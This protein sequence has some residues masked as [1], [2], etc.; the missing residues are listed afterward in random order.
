MSNA[1]R[2]IHV[3]GTV[4]ALVLLAGTASRTQ[5]V[6][7]IPGNAV[8]RTQ[9]AR[10]V[11]VVTSR[12]DVTARKLAEA[13]DAHLN[14]LP[15]HLEVRVGVPAKGAIDQASDAAMILWLGEDGK[16]LFVWCPELED[17]PRPVDV[18]GSP[19][20]SQAWLEA[21]ATAIYSDLLAV[22]PEP[23][24]EA[25]PEE[26][27]PKSSPPEPAASPPPPEARAE[28]SSAEIE[29]P[30]GEHV[31]E[32]GAAPKAEMRSAPVWL[33]LRAAYAPSWPIRDAGVQHGTRLGI[34]LFFMRYLASDI[35]AEMLPGLAIR[36]ERDTVTLNRW[37]LRLSVRGL[38]PLRRFWV[39]AGVGFLLELSRISG[40][41]GVL[42]QG[43]ANRLRAIPGTALEIEAGGW[44]FPWL[45][46]TMGGDLDLASRAQNY[47]VEGETVAYVRV[48][49]PAVS[50]GIVLRLPVKRGEP[51]EE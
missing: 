40:V 6:R 35:S 16:R 2:T 20:G 19:P 47:T 17:T 32:P 24:R 39:S 51:N 12:R 4:L 37:P 21:L 46:V 7:D 42:E 11:F 28:K 23:V 26:D 8:E 25:F 48:Q 29:E 10:V 14:T 5:G 13:L 1:F 27:A 33:G 15:A 30:S 3:P 38:L 9:E 18:T 49:R 22:I 41:D 44:I 43:S 36:G 34:A 50:V 31:R 45:G